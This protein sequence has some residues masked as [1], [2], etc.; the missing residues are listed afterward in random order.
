MFVFLAVTAAQIAGN[1]LGT[2]GVMNRKTHAETH[3]EYTGLGNGVQRRPHQK[4]EGET[5]AVAYGKMYGTT[6]N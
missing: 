3:G 6:Y 2:H 1:S 4:T 5:K